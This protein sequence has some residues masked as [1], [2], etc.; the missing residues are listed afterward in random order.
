MPLSSEILTRIRE[1]VGPDFLVM[2]RLSMLDLVAGGSVKGEVQSLAQIK[3]KAGANLIN[4]GIG[5]HESR[6]PTIATMVPRSGFRFVTKKLMGSVGI[7]LITTNRFN[8]PATCE[9]ALAEG[10]ADMVSMARPFLADPLSSKKRD[11]HA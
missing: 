9:E 6:I 3:E 1:A 10:C 8:D 7:P 5:W 2:Y 11:C 4:T